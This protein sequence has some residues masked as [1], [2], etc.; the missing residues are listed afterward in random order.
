VE[1]SQ[2]TKQEFEALMKGRAYAEI[3]MVTRT[4]KL[5]IHGLSGKIIVDASVEDLLASWKR[6]LSSGA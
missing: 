2:K 6:M 3:G 5:R 4:P 1:V